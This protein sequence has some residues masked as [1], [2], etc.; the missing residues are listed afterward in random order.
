M[1][2]AP[3]PCQPV[4]PAA[5]AHRG[6]RRPLGLAGVAIA[7]STAMLVIVWV[8]IALVLRWQWQDTDRKSVV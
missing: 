8:S 6:W 2:V 1:S 7:F 3:A 4:A 5:V